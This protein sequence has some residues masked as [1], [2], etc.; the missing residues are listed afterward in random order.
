MHRLKQYVSGN[1][2]R[3]VGS[4]SL[5]VISSDGN[6][7][8]TRFKLTRRTCADE[9]EVE[10]VV[11]ETEAWLTRNDFTFVGYSTL[12]DKGGSKGFEPAPAYAVDIGLVSWR[13]SSVCDNFSTVAIQLAEKA[14]LGIT[15]RTSELVF[16]TADVCITLSDFHDVPN[17][18]GP[19]GTG[20]G[21]F[22]AQGQVAKLLLWL[23]ALKQK[24]CDL[25]MINAMGETVSH[26]T[27]TDPYWVDVRPMAVRI[28]SRLGIVRVAASTQPVL[29]W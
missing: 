9:A 23:I 12:D 4:S 21:Q 15:A 5:E 3:L 8:T 18:I 1:K 20:S 7:R 11:A 16:S 22:V 2:T 6:N 29:V 25:E 13:C 10:R 19:A 17:A 27:L 14:E 24:G 26:F 28:A